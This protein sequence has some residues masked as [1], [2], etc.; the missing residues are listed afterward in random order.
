MKMVT[1]IGLVC[2]LLLPGLAAAQGQLVAAVTGT[3]S[4]LVEDK[5]GDMVPPQAAV[6]AT[7]S[8]DTSGD[9][10]VATVT[11]TA[12]CTGGLGL[13][14]TFEAQYNTADNSFVGMY[15]DIP[16]SAPNKALSLVNNGGYSWTASL[17]GNAPSDTGTRAYDLSFSFEIPDTAAFSGNALPDDLTYSGLLNTT[18]QVIVPLVIPQ[19]NI[20][21]NLVFDLVFTG[22]WS[23]TS[24]P[25]V[26]GTAVFTGSATG[27]FMSSNT[28][29]VTVTAP[30][31][32]TLNIP[33]QVS[34]SFGGSLFSV[35]KDTVSFQGSWIGSGVNQTFGGDIKIDIE[36]QDISSF[37]FSVSG[38]IP[39]DT[40][41]PLLGVIHIP[42][43]VTGNFPLSIQ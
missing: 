10:V 22:D 15:S 12:S 40:G 29:I 41:Y 6:Q 39:V 35:D 37:P 31:L 26:D 33:V 13:H 36:F 1:K 19:A 7:V 20:N 25:L 38:V 14:F 24:V 4:G 34:G 23:A 21:Q 43:A 9:S 3:V 2:A 42:F 5:N 8:A 18:K 16:G 17:N 27:S 28:E 30:G 11:G 32:G